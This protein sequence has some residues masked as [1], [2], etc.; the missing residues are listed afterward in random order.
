MLVAL[1]TGCVKM[2]VPGE[3]DAS[4]SGPIQPIGDYKSAVQAYLHDALRDSMSAVLEYAQPVRDVHLYRKTSGVSH[5]VACWRVDVNVNAKNASGGY[6]GFQRY[7]FW[8]VRDRM[9]DA[10]SP[11]VI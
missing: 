5:F 3:L 8:F 4:K 1:L 9:I 2:V 6:I 10:Q 11:I 7:S